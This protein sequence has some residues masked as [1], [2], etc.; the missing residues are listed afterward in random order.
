MVVHFQTGGFPAGQSSNTFS[1][2]KNDID[3]FDWTSVDFAS[4]AKHYNQGDLL[5]F[6]MEA[7]TPNEML[8]LVNHRRGVTGGRTFR[9]GVPLDAVRVL[10]A[11]AL[12][13]CNKGGLEF[14]QYIP[15][16]HLLFWGINTDNKGISNGDTSVKFLIRPNGVD[17]PKMSY[18]CVN[19]DT[20]KWYIVLPDE[21]YIFFAPAENGDEG[22]NL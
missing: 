13:M 12:T 4:L 17:F 10:I 8:T 1:T 21:D 7:D 18:I 2:M 15:H 19:P 11:Q 20:G 14:E 3:F 6:D 22:K 16:L 5:C 9:T